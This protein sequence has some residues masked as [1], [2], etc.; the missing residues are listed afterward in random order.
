MNKIRNIILITL[1]SLVIV[2]GTALLFFTK[3]A[4]A[5]LSERRS[6]AQKPE[7]SFSSLLSGKFMS[8]FEDF[9]LDQFPLRDTFRRVKTVS[10]LYVFRQKANHG[11]YKQG[12][13]LS[14]LEYPENEEKIAISDSKLKAVYDKYIAGSDCRTYLSVIPDKNYFLA[15]TG[16][17]P[18][19]NYEKVLDKVKSDLSFAEYIDI[20]PLLELSDYYYTDQ[21]W[22]QEKVV[23]VAQTLAEA[24]GSEINTDFTENKSDITL[25]G[26][27]VGQLALKSRGD[28][29]VYLTDDVLDSCRVTS[30][31]T[32]EAKEG[33]VYDFK[34]AAGK[35]AYELFLSGSEP[36]LTIEN[37]KAENNK[38]LVIFRDSFTSSLAPLLTS[39]YSKITLI[40]LRYIKSD[41]VGNLMT[42]ENQDV[43][44]LYSTLVLNNNVSM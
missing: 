28:E 22:R 16:G 17:Y 31:A 1:T 37:P 7:I 10:S 29:L 15:P 21:H 6:L 41:F 18:V 12:D 36:F 44:F 8:D 14:K 35:D 5:S 3:P 27:Y 23:D 4:Q 42:F 38:E 25:Y 11:L 13:Y 9:T 32:G 40:D 33:A 2:A 26:A 20:F 34:K 19:M 39:G 30:Y 24:M 43:L